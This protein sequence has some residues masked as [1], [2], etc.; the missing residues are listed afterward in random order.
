MKMRRVMA[1]KPHKYGTRHLTAGEE[2]ELPARH[3]LALLAS[4]KVSYVEPHKRPAPTAVSPRPPG[5]PPAA[6]VR[7]SPTPEPAAEIEYLRAQAEQLGI[8]VDGRWGVVRLQH[9]IAKVR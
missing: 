8:E 3:A 9:E 5:E 7:D 1:V 6:P 2:Y 4:K